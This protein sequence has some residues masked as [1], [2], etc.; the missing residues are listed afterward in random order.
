MAFSSLLLLFFFD[1]LSFFLF[2]QRVFVFFR[3]E[4]NIHYAHT[5]MIV[6][7]VFN[8]EHHVIKGQNACEVT[9]LQMDK[10]G[11]PIQSF[12]F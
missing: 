9:L 7:T 5:A 3:G 12:F 10:S 4:C 1:L 8:S 11:V 6:G 2:L